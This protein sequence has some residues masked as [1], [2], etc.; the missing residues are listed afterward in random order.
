VS[1]TIEEDE[2]GDEDAAV[3]VADGLGRGAA[4]TL[5][6]NKAS[7]AVDASNLSLRRANLHLADDGNVEVRGADLP[8]AGAK[9]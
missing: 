6:A 9:R 4:T 8:G 2:E 5:P 1:L 7:V 3:A